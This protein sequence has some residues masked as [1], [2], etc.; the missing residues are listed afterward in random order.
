[1]QN[2]SQDGVK[3]VA[4]ALVE[5]TDQQKKRLVWNNEDF[6]NCPEFENSMKNLLANSP[7]QKFSDAFIRK[8]LMIEDQEKLDEIFKKA[9]GKLKRFLEFTEEG[10][11]E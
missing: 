11:N 5:L 8:T 6:I 1:M 7:K 4:A 3:E 10:K 2:K 9:L